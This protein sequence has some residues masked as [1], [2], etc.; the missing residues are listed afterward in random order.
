MVIGGVRE[1]VETQIACE[2]LIGCTGGWKHSCLV[3]CAVRGI[4]RPFYHPQMVNGESVRQ[5]MN[6]PVSFKRMID[7]RG[8]RP[9]RRVVKAILSRPFPAYL[10]QI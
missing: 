7:R 5:S 1:E 4:D 9:M 3:G 6:Q 2:V 8:G 10:S